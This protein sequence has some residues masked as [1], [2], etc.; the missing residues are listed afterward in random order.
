MI[1]ESIIKELALRVHELGFVSKAGALLFEANISTGDGDG[2][3]TTA[4]VAPFTDTRMVDVSPHS[5]ETGICFFKAGP[6]R[7]TSQDYFLSTR[8]NEVTFTCWVNGDRVKADGTD[9]EETIVK[10]L[11]AYRIPI[12]AGSPVRMAEI[13]YLGDNTGEAINRWGWESKVLRYNE[14][15]HRILQHRF[16]IAYV[17][18]TGC[19]SQTV[20][21]VNPSC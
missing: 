10:A 17:V 16:R 19:Y 21:V 12:Q 6:T 7:V 4:Q 11:R 14:P 8:E 18:S 3:L 9:I 5:A 1:L 20:Q 13:E 2:I 15:P